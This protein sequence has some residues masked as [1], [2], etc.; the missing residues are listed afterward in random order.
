[1]IQIEDAMYVI[2]HHKTGT[3][4]GHNL[5]LLVH[6]VTLEGA[7]HAIRYAQWRLNSHLR[8]FNQAQQTKE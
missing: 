4:L 6:V 5:L 1:M 7:V 2:Q 3:H 8:G